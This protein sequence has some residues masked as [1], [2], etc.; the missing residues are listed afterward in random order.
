MVVV[1]I[2][3]Y[4]DNLK[5]NDQSLS[6]DDGLLHWNLMVHKKNVV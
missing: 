6:V 2:K 5:F 4:E 3:R 1:V